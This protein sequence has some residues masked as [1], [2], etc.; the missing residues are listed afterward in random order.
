MDVIA[1]RKEGNGVAW[2]VHAKNAT[3]VILRGVFLTDVHLALPIVC[4]LS[5][6]LLVQNLRGGGLLLTP[7]VLLIIQVLL[8]KLVVLLVQGYLAW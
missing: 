6:V 1:A 5:V 4:Q 8:I 3:L 7:I 2:L